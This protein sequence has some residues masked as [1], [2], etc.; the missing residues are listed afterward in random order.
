MLTGKVFLSVGLGVVRRW[1][2][3]E[4]ARQCAGTATRLFRRVGGKARGL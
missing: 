4:P 3:V 2:R 1:S